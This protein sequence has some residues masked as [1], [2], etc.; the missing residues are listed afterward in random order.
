MREG[1]A[2]LVRRG[3]RGDDGGRLRCVVGALQ[4]GEAHGTCALRETSELLPAQ[5]Q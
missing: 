1:E 4:G 2:R 3:K 5:R